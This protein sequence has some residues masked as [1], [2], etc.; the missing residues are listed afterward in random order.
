MS[1]LSQKKT[2][3]KKKAAGPVLGAQRADGDKIGA[4]LWK[5]GVSALERNRRRARST[6]YQQKKNRSSRW[7]RGGAL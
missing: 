3:Q 5:R 2:K 1:D 6:A 4:L 7:E